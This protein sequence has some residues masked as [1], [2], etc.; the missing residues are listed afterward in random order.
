MALQTTH[1]LSEPPASPC[2]PHLHLSC[3]LFPQTV[4]IL[5]L[6]N[7]TGSLSRKAISSMHPPVHSSHWL[8]A[9]PFHTLPSAS[10]PWVDVPTTVYIRLSLPPLNS[11]SSPAFPGGPYW[12]VSTPSTQEPHA[13]ASLVVQWLRI[14]LSMQKTQVHSLVWEDSTCHRVTKPLH[15]NYWSPRLTTSTTTTLCVDWII[16]LLSPESSFL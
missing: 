11:P 1:S 14:H 7:L 3:W 6:H 12:R 5:D 16:M 9:M 10:S 15:H 13:R 2:L 8:S 4:W